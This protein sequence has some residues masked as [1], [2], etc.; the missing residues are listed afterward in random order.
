M[1]WGGEA[2]VVAMRLCAVMRPAVAEAG[3]ARAALMPANPESVRPLQQAP[4]ARTVEQ[5][6]A[7]VVQPTRAHGSPPIELVWFMFPHRGESA[8]FAMTAPENLGRR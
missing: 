1:R 8:A 6:A 2:K 5:V 3:E 4:L 7:R